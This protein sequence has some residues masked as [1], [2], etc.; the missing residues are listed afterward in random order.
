[1]SR[2]NSTY[3]LDRQ[4]WE[5]CQTLSIQLWVGIQVSDSLNRGWTRGSPTWGPGATPCS[6]GVMGEREERRQIPTLA[7]VSTALMIRDCLCF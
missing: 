6:P 7:R 4:T 3:A 2:E 1:M 5:G